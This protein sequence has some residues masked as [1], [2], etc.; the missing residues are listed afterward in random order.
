M[1]KT[2]ALLSLTLLSGCGGGMGDLR[3]YVAEVQA[4]PVP[5]NEPPVVPP[6]FHSVPYQVAQ[7][8]SPFQQVRVTLSEPIDLGRPDCPQPDM[9]RTRAHLEAYALDSLDLKGTLKDGEQ[10]WALLLAG[11][12]NVYTV[13]QG[14]YLGL[15][16]GQVADI[17]GEAVLVSEWIPDGDGCWNQRDTKL[18]LAKD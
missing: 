3:Q 11:D 10:F 12:G 1:R 15:Y 9:Q 13:R 8:R 17:D 5:F 18:L 7:L 6:Q 4:T 2:I 14:D 16:H